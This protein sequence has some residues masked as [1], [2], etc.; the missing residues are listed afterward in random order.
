MCAGYGGGWLAGGWRSCAVRRRALVHLVSRAV[1]FRYESKTP[2]RIM[3]MMSVCVIKIR[4]L[5]TRE[6]HVRRPA[7]DSLQAPGTSLDIQL[8]SRTHETRVRRL[9]NVIVRLSDRSPAPLG[10][11]VRRESVSLSL[12]VSQ[13]SQPLALPWH[14]IWPGGRYAPAVKITGVGPG[15][16]R[17]RGAEARAAIVS[18]AG[19]CCC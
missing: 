11:R 5:E 19:C 14:V 6:E 2:T 7:S 12:S 9:V 8:L 1:R 16:R 3:Y 18:C 10:V 13:L 4:T 15:T 17:R